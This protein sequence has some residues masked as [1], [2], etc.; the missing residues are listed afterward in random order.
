MSD[1]GPGP[2]DGPLSRR[3][4]LCPTEQDRARLLEMGPR[5]R[6]ARQIAAGAVGSATLLTIGEVP[7]TTL[8]LFMVAILNLVTLDW[9]IRRSDHP[10]RVVA[11]SVLL[12]ITSI[13]AGAALTPSGVGVLPLIAVPVAVAAMRFRPQVV[14]A[15]SGF[16]ALI[17]VTA[18]LIN[19]PSQAL[20]DPIPIVTVLATLIGI[21]AVTTALMDAEWH[22]RNESVLDPLTGLLNRKGLEARF[23][24]IG[25]QARLVD[26]PV[27]MVMCDLDNFKR[28]NDGYGHERGDAVLREVSAALRKSL[29][30][31]ELLYRLGG[32][33]F[34]LL[35]P[36][37]SLLQGHEIA[38]GLR[39]AVHRASPGGV[40]ITAS[41]GVS[42]A[43]GDAIDF[44]PL[45]TA[46][47]DALYL[48][49][50]GGRNQVVLAPVQPAAR[51]H[52][53]R[54]PAAVLSASASTVRERERN[55][56]HVVRRAE[57]ERQ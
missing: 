6:R 10:E 28:V 13:G 2:Q 12:F 19:G 49:K 39:V 4:W 24:E 47:D 23:A 41:L 36:G 50:R 30:N 34:L 31:F 15:A 37:V 53:R 16:A 48:A 9:R 5:V 57:A 42:I 35:L 21:T 52:T 11:T 17:A 40:N 29:R 56:G 22:Y 55:V 51:S 46:A 38:E 54:R 44:V 45:Y 14:W 18:A 3:G 43:S 8:P 26:Q 25:E 7:W 32:E 20:A 27:C 33:E 1:D